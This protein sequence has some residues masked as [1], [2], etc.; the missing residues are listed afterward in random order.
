MSTS[1]DIA[2]NLGTLRHRMTEAA[3]RAGRSPE[4]VTLVGI[5]KTVDT[6]RIR[7]AF[8]LGL[9]DF[10]E[11]RVQ[12]AEAKI[13]ELEIPATWHMVGHL[14]TNKAKEAVRLFDVIHSVDSVHVAAAISRRA[15]ASGKVMRV[16]LEVNVSGEPQKYG[17]RP[18]EVAAA[19]AEIL[20]LPSL[21][22]EG[23]MTVAPLVAT[24]EEARP[25]FR[26]LRELR[27]DLRLR[28]PQANWKHLSMGMTDDFEVAIEE[29]ATLVRIGR[30]IFG[31]RQSDSRVF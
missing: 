3:R 29:G 30:A 6:A 17:F 8:A 21:D 10:G 9:R 24:P 5:T 28:F 23:L 19:A 2:H 20:P 26:Q 18:E 12:E 13:G 15:Q 7:E 25:F 16:L 1:A 11:N 22:V 27:D 31:E 4:D 14:Q